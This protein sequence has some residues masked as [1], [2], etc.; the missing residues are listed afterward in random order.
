MAIAVGSM[1]WGSKGQMR[2]MHAAA[3]GAQAFHLALIGICHGSCVDLLV[4]GGTGV[5]LGSYRHLHG[6]RVNLAYPRRGVLDMD[7]YVSCYNPRCIAQALARLLMQ[8][9]LTRK[10]KDM[11]RKLLGR[12]RWA[13]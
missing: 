1:P 13:T 10:M 11:A 7:C 9:K 3:R 4:Q 5:L 8:L 12:M 6:G 2:R